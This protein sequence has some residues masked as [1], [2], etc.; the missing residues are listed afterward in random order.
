[1]LPSKTWVS[2]GGHVAGGDAVALPEDLP[3]GKYRVFYQ[4]TDGDQ[5]I[6]TGHYFAVDL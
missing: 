6:S 1:M 3:P 2:P 5:V 4:V